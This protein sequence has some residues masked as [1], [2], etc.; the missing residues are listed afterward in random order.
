MRPRAPPDRPIVPCWLLLCRRSIPR[1]PRSLRWSPMTIYYAC[2]DVKKPLGGVRMIYRHVDILNEAGFSAYVLHSYAPY[3]CTWFD[4]DTPVRHM[5]RRPHVPGVRE[6]VK[7]PVGG[8]SSLPHALAR[9]IGC[10]VG[11]SDDSAMALAS[12][13]VLAV[14]GVMAQG[15]YRIYPGAP[16]VIFNQGAYSTFRRWTPSTNPYARE[17]VIGV[18]TVSSDSEAYLRT[19]FPELPIVR[20]RYS[21]DPSIFSYSASKEKRIAYMPRKNSEHAHQVLSILGL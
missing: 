1:C 11:H 8:Y 20:V 9:A 15:D 7:G 19:A 5:F 2:P 6:V 3:T 17:D 12:G 21:I 10:R 4:H 18:M 13:D 16:R 14:S